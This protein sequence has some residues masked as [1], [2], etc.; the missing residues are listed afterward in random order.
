M[1]QCM[2]EGQRN[3]Q[4]SFL[5]LQCVGPEDCSQAVRFDG[6]GV[7]SLARKYYYLDFKSVAQIIYVS[8]VKKWFTF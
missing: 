1:P 2:S 6:Q 4:E 3:L 8:L 7:I 5:S